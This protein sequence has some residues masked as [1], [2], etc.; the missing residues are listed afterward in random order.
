MMILLQ[1]TAYGGPGYGPSET[2]AFGA[3]YDLALEQADKVDDVSEKQGFFNPIDR[4]FV[5]AVAFPLGAAALTFAALVIV[6]S[7][8]LRSPWP[9]YQV[10]AAFLLFP[11]IVEVEVNPA[12]TRRSARSLPD[13]T[14]PGLCAESTLCRLLQT[15]LHST[16]MQLNVK[17]SP[18][19][20]IAW[21]R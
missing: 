11:S 9:A 17:S 15:V 21:R 16:V 12:K 18:S 10:A 19:P 13:R 6:S 3:S 7:P 8:S 2:T 1:P 4:L 5:G 14:R 20:R